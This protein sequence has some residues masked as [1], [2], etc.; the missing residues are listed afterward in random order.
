MEEELAL[1]YSLSSIEATT[2]FNYK[3][4]FNGFFS[5]DN[6]SKTKDGAYVINLDDTQSKGT[7][8]ILLFLKKNVAVY[9]DSFGIEYIPQELL[10]K[11]KD[12]SVTHYIFRIQ[13]N[14]S[15]M[16]GFHCIAFIEYILGIHYVK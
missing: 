4:R 14:D 10:I 3:S 16:C 2:Y 11:L 1:L 13:D 7:H 12:K 15:V 5:R 8:W 6:L 9:I